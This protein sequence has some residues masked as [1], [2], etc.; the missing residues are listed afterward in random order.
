[1]N[2]NTQE[3]M[4]LMEVGKRIRH[5]RELVGLSQEQMAKN[6]GVS[7][8]DYAE[9]ESGR[10]DFNFTFIYK[11]A[12]AF[13]VDPTDLLKGSSPTLKNYELSRGGQGLP[14]TRQSE[15]QYKNLAA[16][17]KNKLAEP[18]KVYIPY[19]EEDLKNPKFSYHNGQEF[20]ILIKGRMKAI[21]G[22][23]EEIL[24]P[25]DTIYYNSLIPH[26]LVA[27]D[28]EDVE[29]YA[30]V[31][32]DQSADAADFNV[33]PHSEYKSDWVDQPQTAVYKKWVKTEKDENKSLKSIEFLNEDKF[34][35]AFDIVDELAKKCPDKRAMIHISNNKE[36]RFFTFGEIS[37]YSSMTANYFESLG[38][39]R[40]DKVML[41]LK[42]HY[43]FWFSILALHKIGAVVI[44][45]TNL[46][47]E[48]D[49]DYRFEAAS[50]SAI[51]CTADGDVAHQAELAAEKC[52]TLKTKIMVGGKRD[53][54]H[55]F[56]EEFVQF[57]DVYER[58]PDSACGGDDMLMF[59]TS[60]TTGYPKIATHSH[61]YPLGHFITAKYWHNVNPDGIHLTISDTGWGKALW[62]KLYGQWMCEAA[63][64]V[65][66]F[67]KFNA[68]D[69][70]PMF[71]KYNITTFCAPPTMYRFFIK[72]DLSK[73]DLSSLQYTTVA[74]EAL[75]PEVFEQWKK[76]TGLSLMEG[77]G[78][79]ETTLTIANL[80]GMTP[81]PGSMGKPSPAYKVDIVLDNG[82]SAGVGETGEIVVS[83][84]DAVPCGL[85]KG[86]YRDEEHTNEAWH[87]G[88]YHTGDLAYRDEDGYF[89][90]VGRIDDVIK[91]SGYRIGP[92]E[93]ESVIMELPYVLECAVTAAPDEIRG[94]VVKATIVLTKGTEKTDELKK[95]IQ[96]YV[97][98]HTA[99]Y[100]YPRIVEFMDELPKTISGKIRRVELRN[101]K[102]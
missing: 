89:W 16:M 92:F 42:R 72:E 68:D 91:S 66:D 43:Q 33:Y 73:Y 47:V 49:F 23:N 62:G 86:Y 63:V 53:G 76:A 22:S 81:K 59:F 54:W 85:Y 35:F 83:T 37:K 6:T 39:K 9:Y 77:F 32:K 52:D 18:Y 31:M 98:T 88:Y 93:I 71:K 30:I 58:K 78:Q 80:R 38:I 97:K 8:D 67:D 25:G 57:S 19:T 95:E 70:L 20:D 64:F 48:H 7:L 55:D 50:V 26:A 61:K 2:N 56:N 84:K 51:V 21:I 24:E 11:C 14:I 17:F 74:G 28:G 40:G 69:I 27:L 29:I 45:A 46:L 36:E 4:E 1:M 5:T 75:N 13:G 15:Y 44:P 12:K 99:P 96:N 65:Y 100:K 60:G 41:V 34:N 94:Q 101:E 102:K 82:E 79:T 87:D 90:Y 3:Q 10:R